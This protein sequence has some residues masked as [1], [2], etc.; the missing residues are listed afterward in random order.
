VAP[1]RTVPAPESAALDLEQPIASDLDS[2]AALAQ[3]ARS[4][5]ESLAA[6]AAA[7]RA[8]AAAHQRQLAD[9][10]GL[11]ELRQRVAQLEAE[12]TAERAAMEQVQRHLEAALRAIPTGLWGTK[13]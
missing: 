13:A 2:V 12:L 9:A 3:Q 1:L 11:D 8:D 5:A 7:M 4:V 6:Q 10:R